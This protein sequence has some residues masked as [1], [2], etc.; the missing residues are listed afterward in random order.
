[1]KRVL[2]TGASGF[3]G[4]SLCGELLCRGYQVRAAFRS[5]HVGNL[6]EGVEPMVLGS[7]ESAS[8]DW[9]AAMQDCDG[10]VH[11]AARA[12]VIREHVSSPLEAFRQV[13]VEG[14]LN[15]ARRAAQANVRRFVFIS[16]IG[17]NG[18]QTDDRP[19]TENDKPDPREDYAVSKMEAEIALTDFF[20]DKRTDLVIIRPPLVYGTNAPGNFD[21]LLWLVGTGLPLP[22]GSVANKRSFVALENLVDLIIVCLE[23]PA[24]ANETFLTSDGE[25]L[26]TTD[27]LRRIGLALGRPVRLLPIPPWILQRVAELIGQQALALRLFGNLQVDISK[28]RNLLGWVPPVSVAEALGRIHSM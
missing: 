10:V 2:V 1:M 23:H 22:F 7:I 19:F 26:A 14:A 20:S 9:L 28:A 3:I 5:E 18:N 8:H 24:A 12:H 17:V 4:R 6:P 21:R 16:S 25:D 11:L 15:V 13:N 27:L